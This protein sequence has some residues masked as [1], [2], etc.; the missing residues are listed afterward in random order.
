MY[1]PN[2]KQSYEGKF[3]PECGTKLI[4]EPQASGISINLGDAN[5]I[6][7]GINFT[8]SHNVYN[9]DNSVHNTH[10]VVNTTTNITNVEAQKT[11]DQ[12]ELES[13]NRK[14]FREACE[15]LCVGSTFSQESLI[16]LEELRI[17][18]GMSEREAKEIIDSIIK[19]KTQQA[20]AASLTGLA[21]IQFK[22]M[23]NA[24]NANNRQQIAT[25]LV[26][27]TT[28]ADNHN[29]DDVQYYYSLILALT[30]P[31]RLV[32]RTATAD[33]N[34]KSYWMEYWN[35]F[36]CL[37]TQKRPEASAILT[38]LHSKYGGRYPESNMILLAAVDEYLKGNKEEALSFYNEKTGDVSDILVNFDKAFVSLLSGSANAQDSTAFYTDLIT[39]DYPVLKQQTTYSLRNLK[40]KNSLLMAGLLCPLLEGTVNSSKSRHSHKFPERYTN[41]TWELIYA[42][43]I[44]N[45]VIA[46]EIPLAVAQGIIEV[47]KN[48]IMEGKCSIEFLVDGLSGQDAVKNELNESIQ[49][50]MGYTP[51][52]ER[53]SKKSAELNRK[54]D[55]KEKE[56]RQLYDLRQ[57]NPSEEIIKA[58]NKVNNECR[59]LLDECL[60]C[61]AALRELK[62]SSNK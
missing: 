31:K 50:L 8:D 32:D 21:K 45:D 22:S 16:E 56:K 34:H 33:T 40:V 46:S 15:L 13:A 58:Y 38:T 41:N 30:N 47:C 26:Q 39:Q 19:L 14:A 28:L 3:C 4:E 51:E 6:S 5:A 62:E 2:C 59:A 17:E 25:N 44:P 35:Y 10:N 49:K 48:R 11:K 12:L 55:A 57:N 36:A 1:C 60:E 23:V 27:Y 18:L 61:K 52:I 29:D 54:L 24:V 7:G 37:M 20:K 9:T 42:F 43:E 53:L